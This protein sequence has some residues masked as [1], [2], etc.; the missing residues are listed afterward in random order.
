M[1]VLLWILQS[2][3]GLLFLFAG[4]TKLVK[5]AEELAKMSPPNSI[6]LPGWFLKF[7]GVVEVLGALG[8]ILPGLIKVRR[9][10]TPLAAIGLIVIMIGAV[11]L[12]IMGP[13]V[14][15]AIV[16]FV[17]GI[18]LAVIAYGRRDWLAQ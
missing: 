8:L 5:S 10:L 12:T 18:F 6:M 14:S 2:L 13:G 15:A 1:N 7:I 17:T 11:V 3:C 4:G 9:G 16:P